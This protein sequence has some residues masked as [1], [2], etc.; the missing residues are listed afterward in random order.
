MAALSPATQTHEGILMTASQPTRRHAAAVWRA[1]RRA[2][3]ALRAIHDEQV[4][5]WELFWQSSRVAVERTGPLAWTPQPRRAPAD[6]QPSARP[7]RHQ[8]EE[9]AMTR[10]PQPARKQAMRRQQPGPASS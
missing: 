9:H 3:A 1:A 7:R 6:R 10:V 4:L 2:T 5:A 8:S